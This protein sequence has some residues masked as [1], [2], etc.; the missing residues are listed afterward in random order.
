MRTKGTDGRDFSSAIPSFPSHNHPHL[1]FRVYDTTNRYRS[2]LEV[3]QIYLFPAW[4]KNWDVEFKLWAPERTIVEGIYK[5]GKLESIIVTPE[6]RAEDV[7]VM[8]VG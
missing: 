6:S 8:G 4:P 5:G 7:V 2:Q 1:G 3:V